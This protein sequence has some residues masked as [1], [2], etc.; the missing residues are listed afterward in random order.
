MH[1]M[2]A[3]RDMEVYLHSFLNLILHRRCFKLHAPNFLPAAMQPRRPSKYKANSAHTG[4][5]LGLFV[6]DVWQQHMSAVRSS[7]M[8]GPVTSSHPR[9]RNRQEP[10]FGNIF[11]LSLIEIRIFACAVLI[12]VSILAKVYC[13]YQSNVKYF[14]IILTLCACRD[15]TQITITEFFLSFIRICLLTY[16]SH[17]EDKQ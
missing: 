8:S 13:G 11:S 3:C 7:E 17:P 1:I 16:C 2:M 15:F 4:E 14:R 12:L 5:G 6:F 9:R 10:C